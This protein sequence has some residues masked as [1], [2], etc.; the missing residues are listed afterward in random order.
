[1]SEPALNVFD[2]ITEAYLQGLTDAEL[3]FLLTASAIGAG[4]TEIAR[5]CVE[6]AK[7]LREPSRRDK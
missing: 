5:I 3:S 4:N 1:M 7:R 6:A 2:E